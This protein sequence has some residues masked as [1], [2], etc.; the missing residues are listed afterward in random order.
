MNVCIFG[1][2][3]VSIALAKAL[4][5]QGIYVDFISDQKSYKTN[6]SR[7]IGIS[8]TNI[9]FFNKYILNINNLLWNIDKI[10]IYS[11]NLKDEKILNF[12]NYDKN[13]FSIIK[14]DDLYNKLKKSLKNNKFLKF[15]KKKSL[16]IKNYKLIINCDANSLFS[17]KYFH[18]K[19]KKKYDSY[20]HTTI[21]DHKN[22]KKNNTAI[23]IFTKKGPLAFLPISNSKT[24][25]VYSARG[26]KNIDLISLIKKYN[27]S[28]S[29]KNFSEISTFELSSITLRNYYY[30]NIIAFGDILHKLH[31]LAGQGFNMSLRDIKLLIDLIKFRQEHGL[32]LDNSIC[33]DFEKKTK[34]KNFL[35]SSGIDFVYEFFNLES[36]IKNPFLSKTVKILGKN[37]HANK[38]F[39]KLA[40]DGILI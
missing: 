3:L 33:H 19:I 11:D 14:N 27:Y 10:E 29:I 9:D 34:H 18:R 30:K 32:E 21:I 4:V 40:D 25:I 24:S 26:S 20:A 7:T 36:R 22:I 16:S 17:K 6:K 8:N 23:Q 15:K 1:S 37:K 2:G 38:F 13:L 12:Q 39:T 35:F 5:N 31:P 28:Y